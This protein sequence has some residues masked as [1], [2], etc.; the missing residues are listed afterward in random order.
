MG[1]KQGSGLGKH[2]QGRVEPVTAST[3]KGRR[4]L[5]TVIAPVDRECIQFDPAKEVSY[6][7]ASLLEIRLR[8]H[9]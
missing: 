3:Q 1:F 5:G 2:G 4:G 7:Y 8:I 6:W 9:P